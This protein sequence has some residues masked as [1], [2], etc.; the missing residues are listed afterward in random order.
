MAHITF[1]K[2]EIERV[3]SRQGVYSALNKPGVII[4]MEPVEKAFKKYAK[5]HGC[6][7]KQ[8]HIEWKRFEKILF[9]TLRGK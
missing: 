9:Q 1:D 3:K 8:L 2:K 7:E 4:E 5:A 6:Q